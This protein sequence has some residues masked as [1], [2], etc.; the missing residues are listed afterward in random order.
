MP[1]RTNKT[2][3]TSSKTIAPMRAAPV[4][5]VKVDA[6]QVPARDYAPLACSV[7]ER[8][9]TQC[10]IRISPGVG[11]DTANIGGMGQ[12]LTI[13]NLRLLHARLGRLLEAYDAG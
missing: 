5:A 12:A 2:R 8:G 7:S 4:Q 6:E 3:A 9:D 11:G 1:A 10:E 13:D